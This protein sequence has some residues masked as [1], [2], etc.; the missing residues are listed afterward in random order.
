MRKLGKISMATVL[1][2]FVCLSVVAAASVE[3]KREETRQKAE[4]VLN[5]LYDRQPSAEDAVTSGVGY[6]VFFNTGYT[7]GILGGA[8]GR[9]VA[10]NNDT[11]EEVFM[12]LQE[13]KTGLGL[14]VKEYSLVFVF[15][16]EDAWDE[17]TAGDWISGSG[18]ASAAAS[19]GVSGGSLEGAIQLAPGVWVY[20]MTTKGLVW[21]LSLK[22]T[23][24]IRDKKLNGEE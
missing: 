14:G 24:F 6:A 7:I 17:F 20:Q 12:R 16:D 10:V 5:M 19:D 13:L 4:E 22:G 23:K 2:L 15:R 1:L 21:E 8:H 3:E 11:G 9:G 18:E